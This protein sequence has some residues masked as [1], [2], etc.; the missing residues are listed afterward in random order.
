MVR[1]LYFWKRSYHSLGNV[2]SLKAAFKKKSWRRIRSSCLKSIVIFCSLLGFLCIFRYAALSSWTLPLKD[3]NRARALL[4][5]ASEPNHTAGVHFIT[6]F[7]P[8]GTKVKEYPDI[9]LFRKWKLCPLQIRQ[10]CFL[11]WCLCL[12]PSR[13]WSWRDIEWLCSKLTSQ[14]TLNIIV[15]QGTRRKNYEKKEVKLFV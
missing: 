3:E 9:S 15:I 12:C 2:C 7:I 5:K 1:S 6:A 13:A 14:K 8:D 10:Q 11:S 4:S